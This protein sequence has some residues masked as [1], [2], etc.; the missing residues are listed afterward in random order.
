MAEQGSAT[1]QS[2]ASSTAG[3]G[4]NTAKVNSQEQEQRTLLQKFIDF[5]RN[6]FGGKPLGQRRGVASQEKAEQPN[7]QSQSASQQREEPGPKGPSRKHADQSMKAGLAPEAG[8]G[9]VAELTDDQ[10]PIEGEWT[11]AE[12]SSPTTDTHR[13]LLEKAGQARLAGADNPTAEGMAREQPAGLDGP[14]DQHQQRLSFITHAI[15]SMENKN[16]PS[17]PVFKQQLN[18]MLASP[19]DRAPSLTEVENAFAAKIVLDAIDEQRHS[20]VPIQP[21]AVLKAVNM[22]LD[23]ASRSM[24]ANLNDEQRQQVHSR[25]SEQVKERFP[26]D[27][28]DRKNEQKR[29][30][31]TASAPGM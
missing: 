19:S 22:K 10:S 17:G 11:A 15:E 21:E 9:G 24:F 26:D 31:A 14:G 25:V 5:L 30:T 23:G 28:P 7:Q 2:S 8:A 4:Q 27:A 20:S 3:G 6:L 13:H 29:P 18:E 1:Q 16:G 12:S